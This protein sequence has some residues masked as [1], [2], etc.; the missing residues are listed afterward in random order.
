V[1]PPAFATDALTLFLRWATRSI[2]TSRSDDGP[3]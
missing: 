1:T 3:P 2:D